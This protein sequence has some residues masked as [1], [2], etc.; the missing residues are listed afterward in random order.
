MYVRVRFVL[1]CEIESVC[2]VACICAVILPHYVEV[3]KERRS[4]ERAQIREDFD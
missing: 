2:G 4:G 3:G 1:S